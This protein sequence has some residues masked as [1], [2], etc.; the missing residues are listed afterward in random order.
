MNKHN[1]TSALVAQEA[2]ALQEYSR[3]CAV[4]GA[5]WDRVHG[6]YFSN[7]TLVTPLAKLICATAE[8]AKPQVIADLGGGTG[9]LLHELARRGLATQARLVNFDYSAEQLSQRHDPRVSRIQGTLTSL[10]RRQLA[11]KEEAVLFVM[12]SVLHFFGRE[13]L[14]PILQK[15]RRLMQPGEYFIHQTACFEDAREAAC[16]NRLHA[17]MNTDKWF[18]LRAGLCMALVEAGWQVEA[19]TAAPAL[20]LDSLGLARR[21]ALSA[22]RLKQIHATL[23]KECGECPKVFETTPRGFTAFLPY[24]IF[25]CVAV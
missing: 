7:P 15:L 23:T 3:E 14:T 8:R 1:N 11:E 9:F 10:R 21:Y 6:G 19:M 2:A 17:L 18:P 12:R 5:E 24:T 16:L 25:T 13:S 20:P 22:A 4:H